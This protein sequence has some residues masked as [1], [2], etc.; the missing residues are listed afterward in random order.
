[1]N[2][3][4]SAPA[5][6]MKNSLKAKRHSLTTARDTAG[7]CPPRA[8]TDR[9]TWNFNWSDVG[10]LRTHITPSVGSYVL[11]PAALLRSYAE[12]ND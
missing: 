9:P 3:C 12:V 10:A 8:S 5:A 6:Y 7:A 1:M 2:T 4:A 11:I